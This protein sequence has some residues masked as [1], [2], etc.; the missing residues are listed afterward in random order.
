MI[1]EYYIE[2][3]ESNKELITIRR[4]TSTEFTFIQDESF[5]GFT[6]DNLIF[7]ELEIETFKNFKERNKSSA[8]LNNKFKINIPYKLLSR[9]DF[10]LIKKLHEEKAFYDNFY[11]IYPKSTGVFTLSQIGYNKSKTQALVY[12]SKVKNEYLG[13]GRFV[14]LEYKDKKWQVIE[15]NPAWVS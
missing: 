14:L 10:E 11:E 6:M 12:C 7:K 15:W 1:T 2:N 9:E 8:S 5:N 3:E 4:N 13:S